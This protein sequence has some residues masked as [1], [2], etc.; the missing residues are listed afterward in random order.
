MENKFGMHSPQCRRGK[1][2]Q[3]QFVSGFKCL[4]F[5]VTEWPPGSKRIAVTN[6]DRKEMVNLG[7]SFRQTVF[8]SLEQSANEYKAASF[9]SHIVQENTTFHLNTGALILYCVSNPRLTLL[10]RVNL[11]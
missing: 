5:S 10:V 3:V 8:C 7:P 9:S 4:F 6:F 2:G 11:N 1:R